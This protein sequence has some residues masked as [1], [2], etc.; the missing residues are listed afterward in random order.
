MTCYFGTERKVS[1]PCCDVPQRT[2]R[3]QILA[4]TSMPRRHL[5]ATHPVWVTPLPRECY[6]SLWT[7]RND[8]AH[9]HRVL[10]S[11]PAHL[12][13][14]IIFFKTHFIKKKAIFKT[15]YAPEYQYCGWMI[16]PESDSLRCFFVYTYTA[17]ACS[18]A[19]ATTTVSTRPARHHSSQGTRIAPVDRVGKNTQILDP[20]QISTAVHRHH[21]RSDLS[22]SKYRRSALHDIGK[23]IKYHYKG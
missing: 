5:A 17:P 12:V 16:N 1:T 14:Q 19:M 11:S 10:V 6:P 22:R 4:C 21:V 3:M 9:T 23:D 15:V 18:A 8:L 7:A 13:H 20:D 2:K